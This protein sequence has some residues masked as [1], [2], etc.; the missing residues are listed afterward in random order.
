MLVAGEGDPTAKD[1]ADDD[2]ADGPSMRESMSLPTGWKEITDQSY[3]VY[4]FNESTGETA[5]D[6]PGAGSDLPEGWS[7]ANDEGGNKYYYN[8]TSGESSYDKP[9]GEGEE[10]VVEASIREV[11][12]CKEQSD[13]LTWRIYCE[14]KSLLP[15]PSS[16]LTPTN[17]TSSQSMSLQQ[18]WKEV[19]DESYGVYYFND[20][21]GETSYDKP[22]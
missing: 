18:G 5:Y 15:A 21:T 12:A 6:K 19:T 17:T 14:L 10:E 9:G 4:Y 3:G 16:L 11:R 13:E 8:E 2:A 20:S 7:E 22:S 1:D